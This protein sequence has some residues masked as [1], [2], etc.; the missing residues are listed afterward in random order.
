VVI[1][2]RL[3]GRAPTQVRFGISPV[4][5][6]LSV[7]RALAEPHRHPLHTDWLRR[8]TR[9]ISAQALDTLRPLIPPGGYRPDFL[10]PPPR[11]QRDTIEDGLRALLQTPVEQVTAELRDGLG[12]T[13]AGRLDSPARLQRECAAAVRH[14]WDT[15]LATEW[16]ALKLVVE[17]DLLHR[18]AVLTQGGLSQLLGEL[19]KDVQLRDNSVEV[20]HAMDI[21]VDCHRGLLLVPTVFITDRVQCVTADHWPPTIYYPATGA[22]WLWDPPAPPSVIGP[23]LG[24]RRAQILVSLVVPRTTGGV[25][26]TVKIAPA[27]A[28]EHLTVLREAGLVA[29]RR[30]GRQVVYTRTTLGDALVGEN[31]PGTSAATTPGVPR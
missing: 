18:G 10:D 1:R 6:T 15:V 31:R 17:S 9:T 2:F 27:T 30:L 7:V 14:V 16:P 4:H 22:W 26:E 8:R 12:P 5:E 21:E 23:L 19:H 29:R 3:R 11:G 20:R 25:A 28:S 24:T 13:R